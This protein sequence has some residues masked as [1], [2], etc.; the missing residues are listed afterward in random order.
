MAKGEWDGGY[1]KSDAARDTGASIKEVSAH[2]HEA[3]KHARQS[4]E[5][6]KKSDCF[7]ATVAYGSPL[8]EEVS[9]LRKFR[10]ERLIQSRIGKMIVIIYNH[11]GP[12]AAVMVGRSPRL[13]KLTRILLKPMIQWLK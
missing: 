2:W 12:L 10:D 8:A 5:I 11:L 4:G 7:I 6:P 3:R 1:D 13:M 9:A